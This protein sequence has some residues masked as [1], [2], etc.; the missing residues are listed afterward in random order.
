MFDVESKT[1]SRVFVEKNHLAHTY[2]SFDWLGGKSGAKDLFTAGCSDGTVVVWDLTRGIVIRT[3][4]VA[5][6][7]IPTAVNFSLDYKCVCKHC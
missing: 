1:E 6:K 5:D 2:T 3:I 4:K 7:A